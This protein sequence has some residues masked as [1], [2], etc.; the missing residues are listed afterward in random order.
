M[1]I[2]SVRI[3]MEGK[4]MKNYKKINLDIQTEKMHCWL[5]TLRSSK[6]NA[7]I[8]DPDCI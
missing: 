7:K 3:K 4:E 5:L 6:D 1:S 8:S 2:A